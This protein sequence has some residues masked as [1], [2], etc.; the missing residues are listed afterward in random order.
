MDILSI[1]DPGRAAFLRKNTLKRRVYDVNGPNH[2]WH[3]DGNDK[4]KRFG[5]SLHGAIDGYSR[6]VIWLEVARSN[7]EPQFVASLFVKAVK[8]LKLVP[9]TVR[10]DRGTENFYLADLQSLFRSAHNDSRKSIAVLFGSSNHNQRI[11]RFWSTLRKGLLQIYMDLFNDLEAAGLL[12]LSCTK[13]AECLVFCFWSVF[14][15]ELQQFIHYWNSH[16]IRNMT[17]ASLPSGV[18][19]F[20]FSMPEF[21]GHAEMGQTVDHEIMNDG[22]L[23]DLANFSVDSNSPEFS[24]WAYT[25]MLLY[26]YVSPVTRDD[27]LQLY[28]HLLRL[29]RPNS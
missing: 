15:S 10:M 3:I 5:F 27:A 22:L 24:E 18:P 1:M 2:I 17:A 12:D 26:H 11:E 9:T 8:R 14:K 25:Q 16:R 21:Y 7:K 23:L 6:K 29:I 28:G 20:L 4:L 13:E 19:N